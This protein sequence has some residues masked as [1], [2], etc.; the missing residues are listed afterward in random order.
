MVSLVVTFSPVT[1]VLRAAFDPFSVE[2]AN[3]ATAAPF[4]STVK[5]GNLRLFDEFKVL[6]SPA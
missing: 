2:Y 1:S 3:A 4:T 6:T 5:A